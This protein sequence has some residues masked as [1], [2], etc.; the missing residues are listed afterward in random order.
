MRSASLTS[1]RIGLT[2][3]TSAAGF[4]GTARAG[5]RSRPGYGSIRPA[6]MA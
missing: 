6:R 1:S 3:V 4:A 5:F 2:V